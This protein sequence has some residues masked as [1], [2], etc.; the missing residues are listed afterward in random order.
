MKL[1]LEAEEGELEKAAPQLLEKLSRAVAPHAPS[2]ADALQKALRVRQEDAPAVEPKHRALKDLVLSTREQYQRTLERMLTE[3]GEALD[4]RVAE[5]AGG[6]DIQKAEAFAV[7]DMLRKHQALNHK[8]IKREGGPGHYVYTYADETG[9]QYTRG[10]PLEADTPEKPAPTRLT[11]HHPGGPAP[12]GMKWGAHPG[13]G[14]HVTL[15]YKGQDYQVKFGHQD[16]KFA[17]Q[18]IMPTGQ[19]HHATSPNHAANMVMLHARGLDPT[20]TSYALKKLGIA[21]QAN[22]LFRYGETAAE[23]AKPAAPPEPELVPEVKEAPPE[24]KKLGVM[25]RKAPLYL[26][27]AHGKP[28]KDETARYVLVDANDLIPSHRPEAGFAKHPQYPEGVQERLYHSNEGEQ[29]KVHGLAGGLVPEIVFTPST[30]AMDGPP[31]VTPEGIVLGGNG[32]T[33]GLQLHYNTH[34]KA[35]GNTR[36]FLEEHAADY[37]FTP[38]QVRAVANPVVVRQ[39]DAPKDPKALATL[40]RRFNETGS[41]GLDARALAAGES[42]RM[43]DSTLSILGSMPADATLNDYLTTRA[44]EPFVSSLREA[45]IINSRNASQYLSRGKATAGLLNEEGRTFVTRLLTAS[46][47]P[48][49]GTLDDLGSRTSGAIARAAPYI[50]AAAAG[51]EPEWDLRQAMNVAAQD[52]ITARASGATTVDEFYSGEHTVTLA[53]GSKAKQRTMLQDTPVTKD[54]PLGR[55]VLEVLW[56]HGDKPVVLSG[57]MREFLDAARSSPKDQG[58]MFAA[59]KETPAQ[60]LKRITSKLAKGGDW[61]D[62]PVERAREVEQWIDL[63]R[64]VLTKSGWHKYL[65]REGTPGNYR[66]TYENE[67]PTKLRRGV[68]PVDDEGVRQLIGK[69]DFSKLD[70]VQ[71]LGAFVGMKDDAGNPL[72]RLSIAAWPSSEGQTTR[73]RCSTIRDG[74][75]RLAELAVVVYLPHPSEG[76]SPEAMAVR[77]RSTLAHELVHAAD[78]KLTHTGGTE[79]LQEVEYINDPKEVRAHAAQMVRELVTPAAVKAA[80]WPTW[81]HD[82]NHAP[83][84]TAITAHFLGNP[85][86]GQDDD[87]TPWAPPRTEVFTKMGNGNADWKITLSNRPGWEKDVDRYSMPHRM[88]MTAKDGLYILDTSNVP[89]DPL[90]WAAYHSPTWNKV[91]HAAT[92]EGRRTFLR[93]IANAYANARAGVADPIEKGTAGPF[94]GPRGGKWEDAQHTVSWTEPA[95][96]KPA[97]NPLRETN[98]FQAH[99]AHDMGMDLMDWIVQYGGAFRDIYNSNPALKEGVH[100]HPDDAVPAWMAAL[101][102]GERMHKSRALYVGPRGGRWADPKHTVHYVDE[103]HPD[104]GGALQPEHGIHAY[105]ASGS[106]HAGEIRGLAMAG[107]DVGVAVQE[108]N[109]PAIQEL[110]GLRHTGAHVFVDSGAFSEVDTRPDGPP[111]MARPIPPEEWERRLGTYAR[112]ADALGPQLYVVAPDAVGDQALT[113]SRLATYSPHVRSLMLQR[114]NVIVPVQ[115]GGMPMTEFRHIAEDILG[116][117]RLVWGIPLKKDA[118]KLED[119]QAFVDGLAADGHQHA[120][121][122]L[123]GMGPKSRDYAPVVAAIREHL[124][125]AQITADSVRITAM[126]GRG[127]D[128]KNPRPLTAARDQLIQEGVTGTTELKEGMIRRVFGKE[129]T[130]ELQA[131][132]RAGWFDDEVEHAPGVPKRWRDADGVEQVAIGYGPDGPFGDGTFPP[133]VTPEESEAMDAAG[134]EY[135]AP[136]AQPPGQLDMFGKSSTDYTADMRADLTAQMQ[137]VQSGLMDFG[138]TAEDFQAGGLMYG[139]PVDVLQDIL[140]TKI[141]EGNGLIKSSGG[142]M[143][144]HKYIKREGTPGHYVYTYPD[145]LRTASGKPI[146]HI[147]AGGPDVSAVDSARTV[148]PHR[149]A[150]AAK[151]RHPGFSAEEHREAAAALRA[152]MPGMPHSQTARRGDPGWVFEY[153]YEKTLTP[154]QRQERGEVGYVQRMLG[155]DIYAHEAA[156]ASMEGRKGPAQ[157]ALFGDLDKATAVLMSRDPALTEDQMAKPPSSNLLRILDNPVAAPESWGLPAGA[158]VDPWEPEAPDPDQVWEHPDYGSGTGAAPWQTP[159]WHPDLSTYDTILVNSSAGKDSQAMLTHVVELCKAQGYPLSQVV[160]VHADLGRVE[161]EETKELAK[162]QAEHYG[163]RFEVVQRQGPDLLGT[164]EER[165]GTLTQRREDAGK[166]AAAGIKT[167]ADLAAAEPSAILAVIGEDPGVSKWSGAQRATKLVQA[168]KEKMKK[169]AKYAEALDTFNASMAEHGPAVENWE[170]D[171]AAWKALPAHA[172]G[173]KPKKPKAPKPPTGELHGTDPVD[174]GE[175]IAWPSSASRYCTSDFKRGVIQTLMTRLAAEHRE[176]H[177]KGAPPMRLL[178]ALGIRA[179]ESA[180]RASKPAFERLDATGTRITDQWFPIH[181]WPES[182]VWKTIADSGVPFH[183]AYSLGM[184]RLSCVFCV[185]AD[186]GDLLVAAKHNPDLFKAYAAVEEKVGATFKGDLSLKDLADEIARRRAEGFELSD[187]QEWVKKSLM[188]MGWAQEAVSDLFKAETTPATPDVLVALLGAARAHL[189]DAVLGVMLDWKPSGVCVHLDTHTDS[190]HVVQVPYPDAYAASLTAAGWAGR[191]GLA[192]EE[193]NAPPPQ[194]ED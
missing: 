6:E 11:V 149:H 69:V 43:S 29:L 121:I 141:L 156:A 18:V 1:H 191:Q 36:A 51:S 31:V 182:R 9:K 5:I 175:I 24:P 178:N 102:A 64:A 47:I 25:G 162:Q 166:L 77:M 108:L 171:L 99:L 124:P 92:G 101:R 76:L 57:I 138:Y 176:K 143:P 56:D 145:D 82:L 186:R 125:D 35:A 110:A 187:Q 109:E 28:E 119:V 151:E 135:E 153:V 127:K 32:R 140:D 161:W 116:T 91:K 120:R 45:G 100:A 104:R 75:G 150:Q 123:L 96:P 15:K 37:G 159:E 160:V 7:L 183:K 68:A 111:V 146:Q 86:S 52:L 78:P 89:T 185:L 170:R 94:L 113:L 50:L 114:A 59:E 95:P 23:A 157:L 117:A 65:K 80:Q 70:R 106:N 4:D 85:E 193:N 49:P 126:V 58:D 61:L 74:A 87:G 152:M 177:G 180:A 105:F 30:S 165:H 19:V 139:I 122:H 194:M 62:N 118:T 27:A 192:L 40:V 3:I 158:R 73:G 181:L 154:E 17:G 63:A 112:L 67:A 38:E 14:Y 34:D 60:A 90:A 137:D 46:V 129:N 48:D 97:A 55:E 10:T 83:A 128:G 190:H 188:A 53:D 155:D 98:L 79:G 42:K 148:P 133:Q 173:A 39:I 134:V 163:L 72:P 142:Q 107:H 168:A 189:G 84:G 12:E 41:Q 20:L 81:E 26:P 2:L 54:V 144:G 167:W 8:Y 22:K 103:P 71:H 174:F 115:K 147:G 13:P 33:M 131:A 179:Q 66:Y 164:V 132:R 93:A 136:T 21:Y 44:S 169:A 88:E 172:R 184:R 16:G 130:A